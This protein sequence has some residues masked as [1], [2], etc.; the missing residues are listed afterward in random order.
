MVGTELD[1]HAERLL[2]GGH[3]KAEED[4]VVVQGP[5][6]PFKFLMHIINTCIDGCS[7][8]VIHMACGGFAFDSFVNLALFKRVA[9]NDCMVKG[10]ATLTLGQ[11]ILFNYASTIQFPIS[12]A[13]ASMVC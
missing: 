11:V 12:V 4:I 7:F 10:G 13:S 3:C 8:Q 5:V 2:Q 9:F 1:V 6:G